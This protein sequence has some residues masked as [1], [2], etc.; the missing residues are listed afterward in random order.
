MSK[1]ALIGAT[2]FLAG[3]ATVTHMTLRTDTASV[4][5]SNSAAATEDFSKPPAYAPAIL[6]K[7]VSAPRGDV[8]RTFDEAARIAWAF[9]DRG[10]VSQTGL[11]IAQPDWPYPT[12]WDIA[13]TLAAYYSAQGLGYI[14]AAE[15]KKRTLRALKTLQGANLYAN[16]VFGRNYDARTGALVGQKHEAAGHG[17]GFSAIDLGRLLIW[18]KIVGN[19]DP[20]L[21]KVATAIVSRLDRNR[22]IRDGYLYG[23]TQPNKGGVQRYQEGRLGYEQYSAAGFQAWGLGATRA[24]DINAN[25]AHKRIGK[26]PLMTDARKLDR[27][28]SEPLI[29]HGMEIG[30]HGRMAEL[31]WQALSLQAQRYVQTG[32][33]TIAS[34]DALSI[35]PHYFYYYCIYCSGKPFVINIH[36][37]GT[38]LD[39]PRWVSTKAAFAW[40]ALQPNEYTWLGVKAVAPAKSATGWAS[41][42]FEKTGKSTGTVTLNTAAVILEAALYRK[43]GKPFL[44]A[45]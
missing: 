44:A 32:Q 17:T 35:A 6:K 41:G 1:L 16:A 12:V 28:T 24:A 43:T 13:S 20:E 38:E 4:I 39:S 26:I 33:V 31:G 2:V 34:E 15:Y 18:L 7:P 36:S 25:L 10:Y 11:V 45:S 37:P 8:D 22:V 14:T 19:S 21:E 29:L 42:V 23:E 40:H 9:M 5:E 30:L 3:A 27:L